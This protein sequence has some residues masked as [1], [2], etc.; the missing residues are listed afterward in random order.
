MVAAHIQD[1]QAAASVGMKTIYIR[2][3]G[4]DPR[5][6]DGAMVRSKDEGGEVD[7]MVDSFLELSE[8]FECLKTPVIV[9]L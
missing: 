3:S 2:R 7:C 8:V 1:L 9:D 5:V 6:G 4:E